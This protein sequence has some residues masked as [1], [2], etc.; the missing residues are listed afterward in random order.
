[1]DREK[2]ILVYDKECVAC[3]YYCQ[4]IQIREDLGDLKLVDAREKSDILDE[5][6]QLGLDMD[7]GIVLRMKDKIFHGAEAIHALALISSR[8]NLFN[9]TN[10]W[11]FK[12]KTRAALLFPVMMSCRNLLLKL[13][14]KPRI[15]NLNP[16]VN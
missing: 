15:S 14:G 10:Y 6:T 8:S 5:V 7:R 3:K 2:I 16:D 12:S 1:M 9:R 13:S 4:I 11:I